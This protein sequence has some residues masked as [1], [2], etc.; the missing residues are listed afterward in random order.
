MLAN[1]L[2]FEGFPTKKVGNVLRVTKGNLVA[3]KLHLRRYHSGTQVLCGLD[4]SPVGWAL[5]LILIFLPWVF[6]VAVAVAVY[7]HVSGRRFAKETIRPL[8]RPSYARPL[9]EPDGVRELLL[10]GIAEMERLAS[11]AKEFERMA[12]W[13]VD[14][15]L[16]AGGIILFG[17]LL[18]VLSF[19]T[20]FLTAIAVSLVIFGS[21][22]IPSI[23]LVH[24]RKAG[25]IEEL[26]GWIQRLGEAR[27]LEVKGRRIEVP[28]T[29]KLLWE[30]ERI[31]E[32]WRKRLRKRKL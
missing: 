14:L 10:E 18:M 9:V 16:L 19:L 31:S 5:I 2:R 12:I 29:F 28:R 15:A 4:A 20:P 17:V 23:L 8:I 30:A 11:E 1:K 24:R 3:V 27:E 32:K 7:I 26:E 22:T 21:F 25:T 13:T 6:V